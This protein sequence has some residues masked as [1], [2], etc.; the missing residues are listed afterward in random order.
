MEAE[1]VAW[2]R[3]QRRPRPDVPIDLGDDD[4]AWWQLS[5]DASTVLTTDLIADGTHFELDRH[6]PDWIG[7]KAI[8]V[9]LSDMAAMAVEP[10]VALASVLF[11][12]NLELATAQAIYRGMW[13]LAD[14]FGVAIIGGDTNCWSGRLVLSVTML[15]TPTPRGVLRR[16][17]AQVGDA[18]AVTGTLGGSLAEHHFTFQPRV[19]EALALHQHLTL[20]AGMD[21]TDGLAMDVSRLVESS[22]CGAEL[23]LEQIPISDAAHQ[24]SRQSGRSALEHALG[25]GEDFELL[26]TLPPEALE[27]AESIAASGVTLTRVGTVIETPGL[28][29]RQQ[30]GP[31]IPLEVTGY[32][33]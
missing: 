21:I 14:E 28:W 5:R 17:T 22:G 10:Q 9:N 18:I 2:L 19:R 8:A 26:V 33:H 11:P 6:R 31:L 16:Q 25:D 20:H 3:T 4:A 32:L 29:Q 13:E 23:W 30:H 24:A 27:Q 12:R 7:R 15:G 1:F